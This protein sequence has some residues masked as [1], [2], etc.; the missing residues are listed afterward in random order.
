ME[1]IIVTD[2]GCYLDSHRGHYLT[3]DVIQFAVDY[4]FII[5]PFE[6]F[7]IDMYEDHDGDQEF[8]FES[9]VELCDAAIDWLN[10][11][12]T[13]CLVCKGSGRVPMILPN[14]GGTTTVICRACSGSGRGDRVAGQNFP[15]IIPE[16]YTWTIEDGDFGL[17]KY[18]EEGNFL[19]DEN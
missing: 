5:G 11:G 7:A 10:S 12:R 15:P 1:T 19:I 13:E 9:M 2:T 16:G 14:N 18:D 6:K 8:P 4:G 17:W 3:R